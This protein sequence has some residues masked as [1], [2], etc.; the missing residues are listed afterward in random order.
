MNVRVRLFNKEFPNGKLFTDSEEVLNAEKSGKWK[1]AKWK[2][3]ESYQID[4]NAKENVIKSTDVIKLC[5]CGC[6]TPVKNRFVQGHSWKAVKK[7][8]NGTDSQPAD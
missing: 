8:V 2:I 1:D 5:E 6:G 7:N 3:N 4:R